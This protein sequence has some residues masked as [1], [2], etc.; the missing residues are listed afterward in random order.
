[1]AGILKLETLSRSLW[2]HADTKLNDTTARTAFILSKFCISYFKSLI[3]VKSAVT[4]IVALIKLA[5]SYVM[6]A[7]FSL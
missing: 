1:M 7:A 4:N 5:N 6:F 3:S 2:I